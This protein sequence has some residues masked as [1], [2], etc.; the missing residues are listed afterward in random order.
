M[1]KKRYHDHFP[2]SG[3]VKQYEPFIKKW[4]ANFGG[5]Y[6]HLDMA[7]IL[8]DAV[9]IA[10][11]AEKAFKPELS[12]FST[13]L[14]YRLKEMHRNAKK[15][16]GEHEAMSKADYDREMALDNP[17]A[18]SLGLPKGKGVRRIMFDLNWAI[19]PLNNLARYIL[20]P[21]RSGDR[22]QDIVRETAVTSDNSVSSPRHAVPTTDPRVRTPAPKATKDQKLFRHCP[23]RAK[24]GASLNNRTVPC[25]QQW[26]AVTASWPG[27]H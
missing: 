24:T 6:P 21:N 14:S 3:L 13:Y 15:Q 23:E 22:S 12:D 5:S 27:R 8:S 2:S 26:N 25:L 7:D 4:C 1:P 17:P 11:Q 16:T 10:F 9:L 18:P 20:Y 19:V